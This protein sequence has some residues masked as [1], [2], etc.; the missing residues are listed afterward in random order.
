MEHLQSTEAKSLAITTKLQ[1]NSPTVIWE[2][3]FNQGNI[4][5]SGG[6]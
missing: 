6:V 4:P 5:M 3:S 1:R 2:V